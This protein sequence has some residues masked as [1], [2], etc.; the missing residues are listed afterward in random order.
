MSLAMAPRSSSSLSP[1]M[2]V[3]LSLDHVRKD[4]SGG[5]ALAQTIIHDLSIQVEQGE[6]MAITGPSGSGKST[7]LYLMGGLDHPTSGRIVLD[8]EEISSMKE[9]GLVEVRKRKVG[10][11]YQ[12]HYLLPEF[13]ALENVAIPMQV[14]GISRHQARE[15]ATYLLERVGMSD[16]LSY[17]PN[18][19][20]GGQQQ[21]VA[22]ARALANNPPLLLGDE[23]TGSLDSVSG[24]QVIEL[25][26][27]L[28]A[29]GQTI[30]YVTHDHDLSRFARRQVQIID[31]RITMDTI[32]GTVTI[33]E[34][35]GNSGEGDG[36]LPPA[37]AGGADWRDGDH[38]RDA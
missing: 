21:R 18:Q 34:S 13:S 14:A 6:L 38:H 23:P 37:D 27:D 9:K 16:R 30:I 2:S 35:D 25:L 17:R 7:L 22:V 5:T 8:G 29:Q 4:L 12:F 1:H 3:I 20:S 32:N 33:S 19:L 31:G 28:N 36:P 24:G 11:I 10:F 15:R 26:Q